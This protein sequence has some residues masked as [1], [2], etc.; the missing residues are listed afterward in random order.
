LFVK[1]KYRDTKRYCISRERYR[2]KW[3]MS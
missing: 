3:N 2:N 1:G